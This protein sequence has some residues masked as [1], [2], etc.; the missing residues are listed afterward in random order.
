MA[1]PKRKTGGRTTP[2]GSRP[3]DRPV[4]N[5]V[6][7][8]SGVHSSSRYTPPVPK[9]MRESPPWVPVLMLVLLVLGGVII[10][11]RNLVFDGN[12]WLTLV[13]LG[14]ILGGLFTATKWR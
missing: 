14:C 3:G 11:A 2:K 7:S 1:P 9:A 6:E 8:S 4:A 12:N 5:P 13:G 10:M